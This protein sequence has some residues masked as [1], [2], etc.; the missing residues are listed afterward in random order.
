[1]QPHALEG[2]GAQVDVAPAVAA[3]HVVVRLLLRG[4]PSGDFSRGDVVGAHL[5]EPGDAVPAAVATGTA[6]CVADG[7]V[8]PTAGQ[9]QVLG[10]LR[11]RLPRPDHEDRPG[12][13]LVG[14]AVGGGV[15]LRDVRGEPLGGRGTTGVWY[16]PVATTTWS[17]VKRP[18]GRVEREPVLALLPQRRDRHPLAHRGTEGPGVLRDEPVHLVAGHETVGVGPAELAP[19]GPPR[20]A[21][22][23]VRGDER[24][25]VPPS[26]PP[27]VGRPVAFEQDVVDAAGREVP[28]QGQT[29]LPGAHDDDGVVLGGGSGGVHGVAPGVGGRGG[30]RS[31]TWTGAVG[32]NPAART[33]RSW[34]CATAALQPIP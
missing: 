2:E 9:V 27:L 19:V 8:H 16:P 31:R 13:Q 33:V 3:R 6:W 22:L 24:E 1:M 14:T 7:Q 15:Q 5:L 29:G 25:R 28:A 32:A 34:S 23:E 18:G 17:A 26:V 10:D 4:S 12:G 30:V 11:P 20:E 21:A